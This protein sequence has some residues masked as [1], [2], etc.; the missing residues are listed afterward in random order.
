[1]LH[2]YIYNRTTGRYSGLCSPFPT[3]DSTAL[4]ER[5]DCEKCLEMSKNMPEELEIALSQIYRPREKE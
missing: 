1:M 5:V 4:I 3:Y 2:L